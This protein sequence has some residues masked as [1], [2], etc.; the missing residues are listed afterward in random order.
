MA[1]GDLKAVWMANAFLEAATQAAHEWFSE[2]GARGPRVL[3]AFDDTRPVSAS[4]MARNLVVTVDEADVLR[5]VGDT[6]ASGFVVAHQHPGSA[7]K[8]SQSD[9]ELTDRIKKAAKVAY[10][11]VAFL[12]HIVVC[13][14][15]YFSFAEEKAW[16]RT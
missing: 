8:P 15:T 16:N 2:M 1:T 4:T 3:A 12:D 11:K 10:P 13:D 7:R 5:P 6:N 9:R 14:R